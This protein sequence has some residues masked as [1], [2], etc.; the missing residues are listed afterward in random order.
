M[1]DITSDFVR[2]D[3]FTW[4]QI[5]MLM[6]ANRGY[7]VLDGYAITAQ[8][9]PD[10]TVA[11]AAGNSIYTSKPINRAAAGNVTI[12]T[13]SETQYRIDV[14][15][16]K[17]DGT[18]GVHQGDDA[19]KSDPLGADNW[20]QY[21]AP[22]IKASIPD[23]A[24]LGCCIVKPRAGGVPVIE[25]GDIWSW[26]PL[27]SA[28]ALIVGPVRITHDGGASQAI[29]TTPALCEIERVV[30]KCQEASATRT[31]AIG[32]SGDTDALMTDSEVPK[33]LNGVTVNRDPTAE[34]TSATAIIAT[35]GGSGDAGEWDVWIKI[36]RFA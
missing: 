28:N 23:G 24:L 17:N 2:G 14:F 9:T 1:V 11:V 26:G 20:R 32:W 21:I 8:G 35:V 19:A 15:Y 18:V 13:C 6:R 12:A 29:M 10:N 3:L 5:E 4:A 30:V 25:S 34:I 27:K 7:A 33:T 31:V 22:I 16:A 36:S